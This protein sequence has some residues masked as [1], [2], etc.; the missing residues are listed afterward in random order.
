M[1]VFNIYFLIHIELLRLNTV[2]SLKETIYFLIRSLRCLVLTIR[3]R[4]LA[5]L[6]SSRPINRLQQIKI[7]KNKKTK[8]LCYFCYNLEHVMNN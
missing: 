6:Q 3:I 5:L 1:C 8:K 4:T 2:K 7:Y